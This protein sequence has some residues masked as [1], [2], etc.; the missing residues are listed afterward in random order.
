MAP[1]LSAHFLLLVLGDP[2]C[3][4]MTQPHGEA[5][6][7]GTKVCQQLLGKAWKGIPSVES[8]DELTAVAGS[9]TKTS[10]EV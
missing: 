10:G 1:V 4:V 8:L 9:L 5:H 7:Q 3:H 2:S 6:W